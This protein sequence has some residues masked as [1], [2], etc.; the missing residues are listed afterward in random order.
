VVP[1]SFYKLRF[2]F[3]LPQNSFMFV[4]GYKRLFTDKK[5][6]FMLFLD[7]YVGI[8]KALFPVIKPRLGL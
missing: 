7:I 4:K 2:S 3:K 1:F 6:Y 5:K 8:L